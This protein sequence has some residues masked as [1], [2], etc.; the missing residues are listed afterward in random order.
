MIWGSG[1]GKVLLFDG[2]EKTIGAGAEK[3][4]IESHPFGT[5]KRR[6][7]H[8]V[9]TVDQRDTQLLQLFVAPAVFERRD[10]DGI[11]V[12]IDERLDIRHRHVAEIVVE[13]MRSEFVE[14]G[15]VSGHAD[16]GIGDGSIEM[17][18]LQDPGSVPRVDDGDIAIVGHCD[19]LG[20]AHG[21]LVLVKAARLVLAGDGNDGNEGNEE[22][23][24]NGGNGGNEGRLHGFGCYLSFPSIWSMT[25]LAAVALTESHMHRSSPRRWFTMDWMRGS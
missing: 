22:N 21:V 23:G 12:G 2:I 9:G 16:S 25:Q 5:R 18:L 10:K 19:E 14:Q 4:G 15:T 3:P 20:I 17:Q 1:E 24:E 8:V 13:A 11:D 7:L 6:R